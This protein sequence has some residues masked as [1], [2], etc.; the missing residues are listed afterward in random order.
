M[1]NSG[2]GLLVR[3]HG[4]GKCALGLVTGRLTE[5]LQRAH[6]YRQF[7]VI[8]P[9]YPVGFGVLFVSVVS[10]DVVDL[11]ERQSDISVR[12]MGNLPT[13][14]RRCSGVDLPDLPVGVV[15]PESDM[16]SGGKSREAY[17]GESE[18]YIWGSNQT[19]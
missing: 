4:L 15:V 10:D 19:P 14:S 12:V 3:V 8:G 13:T 16:M 7:T 11:H 5:Y 9:T 1:F 2:D 18:D 17:E 6:E